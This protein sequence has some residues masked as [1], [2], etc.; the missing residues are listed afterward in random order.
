MYMTDP[1]ADML[2]RIRNAQA[3]KKTTVLVP[4]S[5]IKMEILKALLKY[6]Y[7]EGIEQVKKKTK[8]SQSG[9]VKKFI[10][11][12]IKYDKD[13]QPKISEIK[14]I[15]KPSRRVYLKS[16]EIW[17]FKKGLGIRILS[18]SKGVLA[19]LEAKKLKMGGEVLLEIW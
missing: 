5:E 4:Y 11:I 1:I 17:P 9:M 7:I 16:K 14:R 15:S 10:E 3:V 8:N 6:G 2:T 12:K 18:T 13:G 19:D